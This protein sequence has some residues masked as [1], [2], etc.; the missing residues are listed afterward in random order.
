MPGGM[1]GGG[2]GSTGGG[3]G[4]MPACCCCCCCC[5]LGALNTTCMLYILA[6]GSLEVDGG[7]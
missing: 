6:S 7:K 1:G 5:S 3:G 4:G 2:P